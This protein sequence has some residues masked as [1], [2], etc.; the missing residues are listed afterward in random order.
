MKSA[1]PVKKVN[2]VRPMLVLKI[3]ETYKAPYHKTKYIEIKK[4]HLKTRTQF[5][6]YLEEF[7]I[8]WSSGIYELQYSND[9]EMYCTFMRITVRD[10]KIALFW[11]ES[12]YTRERYPLWQFVK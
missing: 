3:R 10:G 7:T 2:F 1:Q 4:R 6:K 9:G 8:R 12:P 11:K 5:R